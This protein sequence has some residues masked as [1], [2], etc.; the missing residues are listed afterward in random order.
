MR[1]SLFVLA[2]VLFYVQITTPAVRAAVYYVSPS[3]SDFGPGTR[4]QPFR[5]IQKAANHVRPGDTVIVENG[6]YVDLTRSSLVRI[7]QSGTAHLWITFKS[8]KKWGAILDGGSNTTNY[9]VSFD[10]V[11]YIKVEG[12]Q[13]RGFCR[14]G[15]FL[16]SDDHDIELRDNLIHSIGR[17]IVPPGDDGSD[18]IFIGRQPRRIVIAGNVLHTVGRFP[19]GA[20]QDYNQDH[21]IYVRGRDIVIRNNILY[22]F[23]A[24]WQVHLYGGPADRVYIYDNT[25]AGANPGR[26]GQILIASGQRNVV[27][28][29]NIFFKPNRC[30]IFPG[31]GAP[32]TIENNI[33]S[34][35]IALLCGPA[36]LN[37][38]IKSNLVGVEPEFVDPA[39]HDYRLKGIPQARKSAASIGAP[40]K[41][42]KSLADYLRTKNTKRSL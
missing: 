23:R 16:N 18:A 38:E 30:A 10:D 22:D 13:L 28:R 31:K 34:R 29:N 26:Q 19:S 11:G 35:G 4:Q 14:V 6:L 32:I 21:G 27:I 7:R 12:F 3:G 1:K 24:G 40:K 33:T 37:S 9:G 20:D 42:A 2:F 5:T 39:N 25:F 17:R 8:A 36:P 15:F 41:A